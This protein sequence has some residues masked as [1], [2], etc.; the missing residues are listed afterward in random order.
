[1]PAGLGGVVGGPG[2]MWEFPASLLAEFFANHGMFGFSG[3]PH[4]RAITGG[5]AR[6]VERLTRVRATACASPRRCGA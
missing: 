4:W 5:S 2:R 6:Y 3:R 1:M